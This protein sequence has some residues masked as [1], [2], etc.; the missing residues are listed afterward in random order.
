M[1]FLHEPVNEG[2]L[3]CLIFLVNYVA[4]LGYSL[5]GQGDSS[6]IVCVSAIEGDP[7]SEC[8]HS[9]LSPAA[10]LSSCRLSL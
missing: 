5:L 8:H 7:M 2:V 10:L 3:C 6:H 9:V 1:S 4:C